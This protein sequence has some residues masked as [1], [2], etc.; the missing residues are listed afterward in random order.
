MKDIA[1]QAGGIGGF[2]AFFFGTSAEGDPPNLA[3]ILGFEHGIVADGRIGGNAIF[4]SGEAEDVA[5]AGE[6]PMTEA[7]DVK[8]EVSTVFIAKA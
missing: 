6:T 5:V 2:G 1:L 7:C 3:D 4:G 8:T